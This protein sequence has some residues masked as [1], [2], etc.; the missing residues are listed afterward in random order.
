MLDMHLIEQYDH[1][2]YHTTNDRTPHYGYTYHSSFLRS[3]RAT[4]DL[5]Y[6]I[7]MNSEYSEF[8]TRLSE[9]RRWAWALRVRFPIVR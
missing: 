2:T 6:F 9:T 8:S 7:T 1:R 5:I 3:F 4:Q